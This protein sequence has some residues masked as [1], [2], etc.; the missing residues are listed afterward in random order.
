MLGHELPDSSGEAEQISQTVERFIELTLNPLTDE[1]IS[2]YELW[3]TEMHRLFGDEELKRITKDE[4]YS[5]I[6]GI[7]GK[8]EQALKRGGL[9]VLKAEFLALVLDH[10]HIGDEIKADPRILERIIEFE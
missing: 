2:E 8:L 10:T 7:R 9:P 3:T 6:P 4:S 1:D 5:G